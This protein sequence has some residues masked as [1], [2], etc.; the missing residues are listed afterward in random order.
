M[1]V[2]ADFNLRAVYDALDER[3]R[4]RQISW[5]VVRWLDRPAVTF[6]TIADR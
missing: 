6:T 1:A 2:H 5:A 3:R 4:E